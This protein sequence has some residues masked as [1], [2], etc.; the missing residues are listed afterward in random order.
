MYLIADVYFKCFQMWGGSE[1][2]RV[3][4]LNSIFLTQIMLHSFHCGC[5]VLDIKSIYEG[6]IYQRL[7]AF[8][9]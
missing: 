6:Y 7:C 4:A 9:L 2:L 3:L 5:F 1:S 8:K